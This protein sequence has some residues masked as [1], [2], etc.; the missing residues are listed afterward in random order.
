MRS[1]GSN[2]VNWYQILSRSVKLFP[3]Y[4]DF[5]YV[6]K[7]AAVRHLGLV[8]CVFGRPRRAFRGLYHC[9][10]FGWN[11]YSSFERPNRPMHVFNIL[12]LRLENTYSRFLKFGLG[13]RKHATLELSLGSGNLQGRLGLFGLGQNY[14]PFGCLGRV[15]HLIWQVAKTRYYLF[16]QSVTR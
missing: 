15:P 1:R 4:G 12:R 6:C 3:R 13:E 9:A 8:M 14:P 11:R 5:L 10:E 16:S 2:F 7:M